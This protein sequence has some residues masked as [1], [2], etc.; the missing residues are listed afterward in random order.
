MHY[1]TSPRRQNVG[2][3]T[4]PC[5]IWYLWKFQ[6]LNYFTDVNFVFRFYYLRPGV[7]K[8]RTRRLILRQANDNKELGISGFVTLNII[9]LKQIKNQKPCDLPTISD[10]LKKTV[11]RAYQNLV[12]PNRIEITVLKWMEWALSNRMEIV[13]FVCCCCCCCCFFLF[14]LNF[15]HGSEKK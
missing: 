9:Q 8:I 11:W 2:N 13:D 14:S 3:K 10:V 12:V 5:R 7:T 1:K 4:Q 15:C 6:I